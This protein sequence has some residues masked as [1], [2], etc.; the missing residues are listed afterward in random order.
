M[1]EPV[2]PLLVETW[3]IAGYRL[4]FE[5]VVPCDPPWMAC[6]M[7]DRG[8]NKQQLDPVQVQF[9]MYVCIDGKRAAK[10]TMAV[11]WN[12]RGD[13]SE[14]FQV[15]EAWMKEPSSTVRG[16][17]AVVCPLELEHAEGGKAG[18]AGS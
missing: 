12:G 7:V 9:P 4:S 15:L 13:I 1:V 10:A 2:D 5:S 18:V 16:K 3:L 14:F 17:A 6:A 8:P 11:D